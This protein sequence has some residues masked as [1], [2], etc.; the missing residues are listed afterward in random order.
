MREKK[1]QK[2]PRHLIDS[3]RTPTNALTLEQNSAVLSLITIYIS[4]YNPFNKIKSKINRLP[5][6]LNKADARYS[7]RRELKTEYILVKISLPQRI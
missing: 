6:A 5:G 3:L 2:I 1:A 4:A 7:S